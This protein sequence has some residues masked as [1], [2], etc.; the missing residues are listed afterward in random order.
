MNFKSFSVEI[1]YGNLQ[2][3]EVLKERIEDPEPGILLGL[4]LEKK[5]LIRIGP[6]IQMQNSSR[7]MIRSNFSLKNYWP[8]L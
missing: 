6:K 2:I 3:T 8:K 7:I 5:G 1:F 4:F